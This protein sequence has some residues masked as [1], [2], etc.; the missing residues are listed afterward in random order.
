MERRGFQGG[1][2]VERRGF[3]GGMTVERRG[4][5]GGMTVERR[6]Y[7]GTTL[8]NEEEEVPGWRGGGMEVRPSRMG[9]RRFQWVGYD[10]AWVVVLLTCYPPCLQLLVLQ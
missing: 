3:Q 5:Q 4:F 10:P 9:R 8:Q 6:G 2:T 1:M 7:R